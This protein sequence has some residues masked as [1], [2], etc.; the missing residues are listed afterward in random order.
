ML[1]SAGPRGRYDALLLL[2]RK[3]ESSILSLTNEI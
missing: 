3:I 1:R 2:G